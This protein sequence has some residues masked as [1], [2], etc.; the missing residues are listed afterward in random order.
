MGYDAKLTNVSRHG[1]VD[2]RTTPELVGHCTDALNIAFPSKPNTSVSNDNVRILW[3]GPEHWVIMSDTSSDYPIANTLNK[4]LHD[5]HGV[6]TVVSDQHAVFNLAGSD[7]RK[8]IAQ[9]CSIDLD[10]AIFQAGHCTTCAF[11]NTTA[12]LCHINDGESYDILVELS[13]SKY[14][15]D[16]FENTIRDF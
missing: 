11:A 12:I 5:Q 15:S 13:L 10:P 1:L 7:A 14:L 8:V 6:A 4:S 2:L 16:W 3:L 9:G